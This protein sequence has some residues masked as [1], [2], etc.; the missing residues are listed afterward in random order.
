MP[1]LEEAVP[2]PPSALGAEQRGLGGYIMKSL[3]TVFARKPA[4][5]VRTVGS[6]HA[7]GRLWILRSLPATA[8]LTILSLGAMSCVAQR[9][10]TPNVQPVK[11]FG[12]ISVPGYSVIFDP[13][14]VLSAA[15]L[16]ALSSCCGSSVAVPAVKAMSFSAAPGQF[17]EFSATG[18]V[19]CCGPANVGPDGYGGSASIYS[20]GSISGYEGPETA[21]AGVFT[22]GHLSGSPP[23]DYSYRGGTEPTFFPRS[24]IRFFSSAMA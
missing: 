23:A 14:N 15:E 20:L 13:D 18:L 4:A 16:T 8:V 19:G 2:P 17:F 10:N 7:I 1:L 22:N 11:S 9:A 6:L 12:P 3:I 21:L 5:S 24:S